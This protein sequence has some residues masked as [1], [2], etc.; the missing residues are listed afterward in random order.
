M[1]SCIFNVSMGGSEFRSFLRHHLGPELELQY[2]LRKYLIA[3]RNSSGS[4]RVLSSFSPCPME[5]IGLLCNLVV[6]IT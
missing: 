2:F 1:C 6:K 4:L 5:K 3:Y